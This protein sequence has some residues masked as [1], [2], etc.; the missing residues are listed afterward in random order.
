VATLAVQQAPGDP[1]SVHMLFSEQAF[2]ELLLLL[3][4]VIF[5]ISTNSIQVSDDFF[6]F[7]LCVL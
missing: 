6:F 1:G 3:F 7:C 4:V 2:E 5:Y